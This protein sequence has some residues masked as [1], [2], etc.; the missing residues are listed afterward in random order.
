M[1]ISP[2]SLHA[3][4]DSWSLTAAWPALVE[5]AGRAHG[6]CG[7]DRGTVQAWR[8]RTGPRHAGRSDRILDAVVDGQGATDNL[9]A[10]RL[11]QSGQTVAWVAAAVVPSSP[12]G[13]L[14]ALCALRSALVI[15]RPAIALNVALWVGAEDRAVRQVLGEPNDLV[16]LP[17]F[18][19]PACE[20]RGCLAIR[21]SNPELTARPVVCTARCTCRGDGCPC[22]MGVTADGLPH[23]WTP[24]QLTVALD[25][26]EARTS[27]TGAR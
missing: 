2:Q 17:G 15:A 25:V 5:A 23:I 12:V 22:G 27:T 10:A 6:A 19:C 13:A 9:Y 14:E 16:P 4:A 20:L 7:G 18:P 21:G 8:P 1:T 3:I 11:R 24:E 26:A